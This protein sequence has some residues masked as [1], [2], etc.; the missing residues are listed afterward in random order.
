MEKIKTDSLNALF[1][2][3]DSLNNEYGKLHKSIFFF[4]FRKKHLNYEN[5]THQAHELL[6]TLATFRELFLTVCP[7]HLF[8][9]PINDLLMAEFLAVSALTGYLSE[10]W[11]PTGATPSKQEDNNNFNKYFSF[12]GEYIKQAKQFE[13]LMTNYEVLEDLGIK[14]I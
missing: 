11:V 6:K 1:L 5:L 9:E 7:P 12:Y 3:F 8:R 2:R 14:K 10:R 4:S 13:K